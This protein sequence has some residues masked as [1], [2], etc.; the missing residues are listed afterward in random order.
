LKFA[1]VKNP[2]PTAASLFLDEQSN[3]NPDK[4]SIDDGYFAIDYAKKGPIW[5]NV[6]ASRHGNGGQVSFADGHVQ[7]WSWFEPT[8]QTLVIGINT[9]LKDR[10]LEQLWK[11]TYP[12]DKW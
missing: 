12:A 9:K 11:S 6:P 3:P 10:D 5:P 2:N 7:R 4:C 1:N 8:T